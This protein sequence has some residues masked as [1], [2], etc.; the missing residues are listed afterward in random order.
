MR[1]ATFS[2]GFLGLA[3]SAVLDPT[4]LHFL[5]SL[6]QQEDSEDLRLRVL[7]IVDEVGPLE[8]SSYLLSKPET[9]S[10]TLRTNPFWI[11]MQ[12]V[13][14]TCVGENRDLVSQMGWTEVF[15]A[16]KFDPVRVNDMLI[17]LIRPDDPDVPWSLK[18]E[19]A[20]IYGMVWAKF[21]T[22]KLLPGCRKKKSSKNCKPLWDQ[23]DRNDLTRAAS[24]KLVRPIEDLERAL[25]VKLEQ[26]SNNPELLQLL[27]RV[28]ALSIKRIR[29][30]VWAYRLEK[31]S[32]NPSL[33]K[34]SLI[35]FLLYL[36]RTSKYNPGWTVLETH[37]LWLE[38]HP[39]KGESD[40][41]ALARVMRSIGEH[42]SGPVAAVLSKGGDKFGQYSGCN[43]SLVDCLRDIDNC[44]SA[45]Q[46]N[47]LT[48]HGPSET[49]LKSQAA[50]VTELKAAIDA[51]TLQTNVDDG[52]VI[53][54]AYRMGL[55]P[56]I[57]QP[58][59]Q[60]R[61]ER[62]L[63]APLLDSIEINLVLQAT[64]LRKY[65]NSPETLAFLFR[66]PDKTDV[67]DRATNLRHIGNR[68]VAEVYHFLAQYGKSRYRVLAD[69]IGKPS[70]VDFL[71]NSCVS[72]V[73]SAC[74][75]NTGSDWRGRRSDY[76]NALK[77]DDDIFGNIIE[78]LENIP[79]IDRIKFF[80]IPDAS[81]YIASLEDPLPLAF[82]LANAPP[83]A[84]FGP[85]LAKC[86]L[87]D[88]CL[89]SALHF[90]SKEV[91]QAKSTCRADDACP[92]LADISKL[93]G[94]RKAAA[95]KLL[96]FSLLLSVFGDSGFARSDFERFKSMD[97]ASLVDT[98]Q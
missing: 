85:L 13:G 4:A 73:D 3:N 58:F 89:E 41:V 72:V 65:S 31:L 52:S 21:I 78:F 63:C 33:D 87:S 56:M 6:N 86:R 62:S 57:K 84:T 51:L 28:S 40:M 91:S 81:N 74:D 98:F 49:I 53:R 54:V 71:D 22:E 37:T 23:V 11:C 48:K 30:E 77:G 76:I 26:I 66:T 29:W 42:G 2:F 55:D 20:E 60:C 79:H 93:N 1:L 94:L 68:D 39:H 15:K 67:L 12:E 27:D 80:Q 10:E 17:N 32:E 24:L 82:V 25:D 70:F 61:A 14:T 18:R 69:S 59:D 95:V 45:S 7:G 90:A 8:F 35:R 50:S 64:V 83:K 97:V 19:D 96:D 38:L 43:R 46:M 92:E 9:I 47:F 75:Y 16:V 5:A 34:I 88:P 44:F 36:A